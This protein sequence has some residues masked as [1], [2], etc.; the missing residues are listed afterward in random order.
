MVVLGVFIRPAWCA[1]TLSV[2]IWSEYIDPELVEQFEKDTGIKLELSLYE[3]TEDMLAKLQAPGGE[4][5]FDLVVVSNEAVKSMI[6]LG[7]VQKLNKSKLPN[8]EGVMKKFRH[9][10]YD[11]E[12]LFTAP[13]QWGTTGLMWDAS[14]VQLGDSPSWALVLGATA[15]NAPGRFILLDTLRD[16]IG[17]ALKF[18]GHSVNTTTPEQVKQAGR[19]ILQGKQSPKC[20]GFDGSVG[21]KNKVLAGS[22]DIAVVYNGEA[23]RAQEEKDTIAY[24]VPK[25]GSM[26]WVDLMVLCKGAK[27]VDEAHRFI[28]FIL[29]AKVNAKLSNFNF[30][31]TPVKASL[32]LID[33]EARENPAIYPSDEVLDRMEFLQDVG[34]STPLYEEVWTAIKSR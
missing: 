20:V 10:V 11:P 22:A 21:G 18:Q 19:L 14:K 15:A 16:Q 32:D 13:Y 2:F 7:L 8:Y 17:A 12:E 4:G 34:A 25:E 9:Q 27:H 5:Q 31:A 6:E 1:S 26:L 24:A 33:K 30:F 23:L 3:A 29:D 28:D